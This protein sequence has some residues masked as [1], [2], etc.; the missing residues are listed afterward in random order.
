MCV[1]LPSVLGRFYR[2]EIISFLY[3][4]ANGRNFIKILMGMLI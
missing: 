4:V 3:E 2:I 1:A